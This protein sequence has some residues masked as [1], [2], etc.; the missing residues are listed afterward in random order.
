MRKPFETDETGYIYKTITQQAV[1]MGRPTAVRAVGGANSRNPIFLVR[2][3]AQSACRPHPHIH[4]PDDMC[5]VVPC[6]R[7][8]GSDGSLTGAVC[9][10][11]YIHSTPSLPAQLLNPYNPSGFT[12]SQMNACNTGFTTGIDV[13]RW[14]LSF[15]RTAA[16][17]GA[18]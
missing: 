15:E 10:P 9:T 11:C 16:A 6:H 12:V 17:S 14:L 7:V 4:A 1:S 2:T 3:R 8:I 18:T 13:K 5:Q